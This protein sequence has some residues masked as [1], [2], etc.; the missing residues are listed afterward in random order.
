MAVAALP[1]LLTE[2]ETAVGASRPDAVDA[3]VKA[4]RAKA[5]P[6]ELARA[7]ARGVATHYDPASGVAPRSLAILGAASNLTSVME[8]RFQVLPVLQAIAYAASERKPAVPAKPPLV[9][10]GE[11]TH[12]G[13]SFLFA[14]RAGDVAEAES[15]FLGMVD[16]DWER[17]MAGDM[18]FRAA[19]EDMG[20]GG[21]KLFLSVKSWQLARS[22]GFKGAR[23]ILRPAVDYLVKGPRDRTAYETILAVL[24]KEWVDLE[25]LASGGWPLDEPGR[26]RMHLIASAPSDAACIDATL[27]LLR[28][29]Y[30]ASVLAEGLVVAAARR[31]LTAKGYDTEAARRLLFAHASRFVLNFSRTGERLYALFQAALRVRSPE[32]ALKPDVDPRTPVAKLDVIAN[33]ACRDSP[34]ANEGYNLLL[35]DACITEYAATKAAPIVLALARMSEASPKDQAAYQSWAS[36]FGP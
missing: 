21:R 6:L 10:S 5:P 4:F 1:S 20:E 14:V 23:T 33:L 25:A 35:A 15:I 9:V 34:A 3:A 29:G 28:D 13:R 16:E 7:A 27:A 12:L 18:L 31:L 30:A 11:V 24:G 22:L 36:L 32:P 8:P 26:K 19:L 17:K 2:V